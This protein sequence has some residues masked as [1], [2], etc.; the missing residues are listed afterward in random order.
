MCMR[1]TAEELED[2]TAARK[3]LVDVFGKEFA[4][5]YG[6][7]DG[8]VNGR[9]TFDAIQTAVNLQHWQPRYKLACQEIHAAAKPLYFNLSAG[10][11]RDFLLVGPSDQGVPEALHPV[12]LSTKMVTACLVA[13]FPDVERTFC[14]F[15]LDSLANRAGEALIRE[16][17]TKA[18]DE[19]G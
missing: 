12:L 5:D 4:K 19:H 7:A 10:L 11:Q 3:A 17:E 15:V 1:P 8:Y 14:L 13:E 18:D 2:V 9:P 16:F 6:W